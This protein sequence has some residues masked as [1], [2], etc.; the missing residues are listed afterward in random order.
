MKKK[1]ILILILIFGFINVAFSQDLFTPQIPTSRD[2]FGKKINDPYTYLENIKDTFSKS[3]FKKNS[4][5]TCEI[6]NNITS[7][8]DIID[9][10][11]EMK[12]KVVQSK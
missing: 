12:K 3:R 7:R 9:K 4:L 5:K 10:L 2:Y 6:L 1:I 8:K 11:V